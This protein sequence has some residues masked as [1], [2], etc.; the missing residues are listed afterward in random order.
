[1]YS[2]QKKKKCMWGDWCVNQFYCGNHFTICMY[3]KLPYILNVY[4]FAFQ[5]YFNGAGGGVKK[6]M[7][8]GKY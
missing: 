3:I 6:K 4:D 5:L 1:M 7:P 2:S 8:Q